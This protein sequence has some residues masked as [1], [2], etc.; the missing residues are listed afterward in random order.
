M[1]ASRSIFIVSIQGHVLCTYEAGCICS[2]NVPPTVVYT[3]IRTHSN[4]VELDIYYLFINDYYNS[5]NVLC[6]QDV[7]IYGS[8]KS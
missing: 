3:C 6:L 4:E 2:P 5:F 8:F 1:H 7:G